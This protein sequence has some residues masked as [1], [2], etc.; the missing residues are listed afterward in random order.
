MFSNLPNILLDT[1]NR[2]LTAETIDNCE[3]I[4]DLSL[5]VDLNETQESGSLDYLLIVS[6]NLINSHLPSECV[7]TTT[8]TYALLNEHV[9][10]LFKISASANHYQVLYLS[11]FKQFILKVIRHKCHHHFTIENFQPINE[12][13]QFQLELIFANSDFRLDEIRTQ[14]VLVYLD[15]L[16]SQFKDNYL[17]SMN[18][19]KRMS[20]LADIFKSHLLPAAFSWILK[21]KNFNESDLLTRIID[22]LLLF[23]KVWLHF[24]SC[25]KK[26][27]SIKSCELDASLDHLHSDFGSCKYPSNVM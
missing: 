20:S 16:F 25:L 18:N 1:C 10:K 23:K 4:I 22:E 24:N 8:T 6:Y 15:E 12:F 9:K 19:I 7:L 11:F 26:K 27:H 13:I 21:L 2:I 14:L 17:N 3:Q 5:N